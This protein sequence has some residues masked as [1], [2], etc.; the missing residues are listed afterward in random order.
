MADDSSVAFLRARAVGD[1][2]VTSALGNADAVEPDEAPRT[3]EDATPGRR[4]AEKGPLTRIHADLPSVVPEVARRAALNAG[5]TLGLAEE[6]LE[7][8]RFLGTT[9]DARPGTRIREEPVRALEDATRAPDVGERLPRTLGHTL[10][11]DRDKKSVR[12]P[13]DA[14]LRV[15]APKRRATRHAPPA[16]RVSE[17][18]RGALGD[19]LSILH[20]KSSRTRVQGQRLVVDQESLRAH[21]AQSDFG[22]VAR[23]VHFPGSC[24][25]LHIHE[26]L[27]AA[28]KLFY[29]HTTSLAY[30]RV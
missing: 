12:T 2:L 28:E 14:R 23:V 5:P 13:W 3:A 30:F 17:R 1:G 19:A 11:V 15:R 16:L 24:A 22:A 27:W 21:L 25:R 7:R 10:P 9:G 29:G 8:V 20:V 4:V 6:R 18:S 26:P